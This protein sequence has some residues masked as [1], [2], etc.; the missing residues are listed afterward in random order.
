MPRYG[1]DRP[2]ELNKPT[3]I[4]AN[5]SL[6]HTPDWGAI[7]SAPAGFSID[8]VRYDYL[9]NTNQ[10]DG[11]TNNNQYYYHTNKLIGQFAQENSVFDNGNLQQFTWRVKTET[12]NILIDVSNIDETINPVEEG[13]LVELIGNEFAR[14]VISKIIRD[15]NN[16]ILRMY[17]RSVEGEFEAGDRILGSTGFSMTIANTPIEFPNGLFYIEFGPEAHEFG[18][19]T[20][21]VY[22]LAPRNIRDI[23]STGG[24]NRACGRTDPGG[25]H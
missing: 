11:I 20:P 19:F 5:G 3:G 23:V 21:G 8:T 1:G 16:N 9:L 10:Y 6:L 22:Y 12:D 25:C 13:R 2:K 18:N 14:G 24:N 17:L 7:G 15:N 4:F